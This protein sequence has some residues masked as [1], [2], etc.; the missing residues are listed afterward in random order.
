MIPMIFNILSKIKYKNK[1]MILQLNSNY[2]FRSDYL[3]I[4]L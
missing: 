3:Y 4:P 1:N 2:K